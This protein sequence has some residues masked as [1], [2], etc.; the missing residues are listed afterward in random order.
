MLKR[1]SIENFKSFRNRTD[2]D[3]AP[4]S[5]FAGA[6]SSGKSTIIQSILLIKQTLQY[7]PAS[8]AL[9]LN[10]PLLKL[11]TFNDVKNANGTSPYIGIS[12]ALAGDDLR[13][14]SLRH[15]ATYDFSPYSYWYFGPS[16][17]VTTE[18]EVRFDVRNHSQSEI[19]TSQRTTS[20]AEE[21]L[22]LQPELAYAALRATLGRDPNNFQKVKLVLERSA[23]E[24]EEKRAFL[25]AEGVPSPDIESI[26]RFH[27]KEV[28]PATQ[29]ELL[30]SK[31]DGK[32]IGAS[33][34]HM[35]PFQIGIFYDKAKERARAVS[36]IICKESYSPYSGSRRWQNTKIPS[37]IARLVEEQ[38]V[39]IARE[40]N[41]QRELFPKDLPQE[42][43]LEKLMRGLRDFR[44]RRHYMRSSTSLPSLADLQSQIESMLLESFPSQAAVEI[45]FSRRLMEA[46]EYA[47]GYFISAVRYLGPLRDEPKPIYPLEA[48]V[49]PTEVGYKGEHTAAVLDLHRNL[50]IEY[51]PS[52][53][54]DRPEMAA[55]TKTAT[56]HDAVVDWLSYVGVAEEVTTDDRGKIGHQLQVQTKGV[57]RFHD[58]TNVGVGVSQVLPI[59][60]MALLAETPCLLIFEQPEL[61][62]HPKVQARLAD[63]FLSVALAGKQCLLETHSEYLVERFRRRI[64]EAEGDSL[65]HILKIYFTERK[66]GE[67][68]CRPVDVSKYGAISDYPEDFFDQS[69]RETESILRAARA[70]RASERAKNEAS[71]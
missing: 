52:A 43:E 36:H 70:K 15:S 35:F 45:D 44:Y 47:R 68:T 61:H 13:R 8:R 20:A 29:D 65:T 6:N 3:L 42:I 16:D 34:R 25:N 21:L 67:T 37:S 7:A 31:P 26:L 69:Q 24:L 1:W 62:L 57:S 38:I 59:I 55:S 27:V 63:F 32:I 4:I 50:E 30:E 40:D 19:R 12:W 58:L 33:V 23:Q 54:V 48:L 56:L 46:V 64:A 28:D 14:R 18:C 9:A 22:Q 39:G 60:V 71:K 49:N 17:S 66:A 41:R 2:I 53:F 51:I 5:I 11:G 10:G